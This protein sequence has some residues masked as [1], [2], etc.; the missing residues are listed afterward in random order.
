MDVTNVASV[1][2]AQRTVTEQ[3]GSVDV[4][5]NSAA[6]LLGENDD[7]LSIAADDEPHIVVVSGDATHCDIQPRWTMPPVLPAL[8]PVRRDGTGAVR[9][10][11][12]VH[13]PRRAW[14]RNPGCRRRPR[15]P[16]QNGMRP[17]SLAVAQSRSGAHRVE[18]FGL[19]PLPMRNA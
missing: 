13:V 5:V 19:T 14:Q 12:S 8:P 11:R 7:V 9:A 17:R 4:L 6:V 10:R 1:T 15:A 16:P 2:A 18:K 3:V